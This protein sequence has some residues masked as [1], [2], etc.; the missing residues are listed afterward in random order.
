M[1][2]Y[3]GTFLT[4]FIDTIYA[5]K[6]TFEQHLDIYFTIVHE[7]EQACKNMIQVSVT[8]DFERIKERNLILLG[9][10]L[11]QDFEDHEQV[12]NLLLI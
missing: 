8:K 1:R 4:D 11:I 7:H 9:R 5:D 2:H 3:Y 6:D 12:I 10:Q